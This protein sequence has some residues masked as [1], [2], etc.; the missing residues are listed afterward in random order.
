M[1]NQLKYIVLCI[2][3]SCSTD[4]QEQGEIKNSLITFSEGM[5][6]MDKN[7]VFNYSTD[8][9]V[10]NELSP[11]ILKVLEINDSMNNVLGKKSRYKIPKR[12]KEAMKSEELIIKVISIDQLQNDKAIVKFT[13]NLEEKVYCAE[14]IKIANNWKI[15]RYCDN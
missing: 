3:I 6:K 15:N 1:K 13:M 7:K 12:V 2:L 9:F 14:F 4:S 10:K 11:G 5:Y 8:N